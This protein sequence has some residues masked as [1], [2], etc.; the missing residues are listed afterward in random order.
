MYELADEVAE[1]FSGFQRN[2]VPKGRNSSSVLQVGEEEFRKYSKG[3]PEDHLQNTIQLPKIK[4]KKET[5][6]FS[7]SL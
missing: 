6:N 3:T 5:V 2:F 1:H 4:R 7:K